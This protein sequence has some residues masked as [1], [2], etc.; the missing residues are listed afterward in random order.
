MTTPITIQDMFKFILFLLGIG[1][2]SY[3]III[4]RN[5]AILFKKINGIVEENDEHLDTTIKQLPEISQNINS[6]TK[7]TDEA[8]KTIVPEVDELISHINNISGKVESITDS[9]DGT[10]YKLTETVDS[11]SDSISDSAFAFR[12]NVNSVSDYIQIVTEIIE[13]IK[14]LIQKR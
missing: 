1:A 5:I 10:A 12:Q 6:I 14:N 11:V 9:I 4:L 7:T 13:V 2:M 3:L 8:M